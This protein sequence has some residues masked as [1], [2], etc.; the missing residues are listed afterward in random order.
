MKKQIYLSLVLLLSSFLSFQVLAQ[1]IEYYQFKLNK[2]TK[3]RGSKIFYEGLKNKGEESQIDVSKI[4][5][6]YLEFYFYTYSGVKKKKI[7]NHISWM[8]NQ[9]FEKAKDKASADV[10][11]GGYYIIKTGANVEEKVFYE[12]AQN[13]GG[14]I[15]YYEIR[16]TNRAEVTAVISYTYKDKS[17]AYDTINCAFEYERKPKTKYKSIDDL[18]AKCEKELGNKFSNTFNFYS[19]K[20]VWYNFKSVK[21]KDKGLKAELKTVK[22]LL[23][24]GKIKEAGSIYLKVY[25]FDHKNLAAAFNVA[26]CYELIGNYPKANEFYLISPD[27]HAKVRMKSNMK[28]FNYLKSIGAIMKIED[29]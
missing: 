24:N 23:N 21:T 17:V 11:V 25:E 8:T 18:L 29:F 15:P 10:I 12:R 16:Q 27:F 26:Q 3:I 2:E 14:S 5:M 6:N 19:Y 4:A 20:D 1:S 9:R 7:Q 22:D 13:V 28:L